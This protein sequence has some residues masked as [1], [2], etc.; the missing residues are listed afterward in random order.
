MKSTHSNTASNCPSNGLPTPSNGLATHTPIPPMALEGANSGGN[1][2]GTSHRLPAMAGS[3]ATS[4]PGQRS[5]VASHKRTAPLAGI[6]SGTGA[7]GLRLYQLAGVA[8]VR[9]Y[10]DDG[11]Q[12]GLAVWPTGAGKSL[13]L[14]EL[15]R[16]ALASNQRVVPSAPSGNGAAMRCAPRISSAR[17][18]S[19][20]KGWARM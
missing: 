11:G 8:A 20:K 5:E 16:Y 6:L 15:S 17:A 14:A 7:F 10:L 4:L 9:S 13:L 2:V 12:A 19:A 3:P 18:V 1:P